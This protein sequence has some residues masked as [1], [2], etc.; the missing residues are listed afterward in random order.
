MHRVW[1]ETPEPLI[2]LH[3]A[4]DDHNSSSSN[5]RCNI[6]NP[7]EA[8]TT[9]TTIS[10]RRAVEEEED[11]RQSQPVEIYSHVRSALLVLR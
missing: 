2:D 10:I 8:T 3:E 9:T 7:L 4:G 11:S 1:G 6:Q 5:S